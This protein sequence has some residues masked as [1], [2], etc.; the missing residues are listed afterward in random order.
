VVRKVGEY[1]MPFDPDFASAEI[2][3]MLCGA[4]INAADTT[5]T[6]SY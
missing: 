4:H 5:L 3:N 6:G 2:I 1:P